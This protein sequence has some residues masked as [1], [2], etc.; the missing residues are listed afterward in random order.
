MEGP[1]RGYATRPHRGRGAE[2]TVNGEASDD[3]S[4]ARRV[5]IMSALPTV[6]QVSELP[7]V[8]EMSVPE[9]F[10]DEN[11]HMNITHYLSLGARGIGSRCD[12][13]GLGQSYIDDRRLT[14][15]TAEHHIRYFAELRLGQDLSVHVRFLERSAKA[16]HAMAFLVNRSTD[17]LACTLEVSLVHVGMDTRRPADFPDDIALRIDEAIKADD[18]YSWPA[19]VC[20]VMGV[21]R[22]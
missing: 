9:E 13:M 16:L 20:G 10:L 4:P 18:S 8:T 17:V 6:E 21:R 22:R 1:D 12:D 14:I 11:H 3:A 2:A 19:P 15:F 5:F 7:T